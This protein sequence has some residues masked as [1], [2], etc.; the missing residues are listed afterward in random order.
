MNIALSGSHGFIGGGL[1]K[2]LEFLGNTVFP[3]SRELRLSPANLLMFMNQ[4]MIDRVIDCAAYGNHSFQTNEDEVVKANVRGTYNMFQLIKRYNVPFFNFSTTSHNLEA[5]TFYGSIK[6]AG[7]YMLRAFV[8]TYK[9]PMVNIR[10][11]SVY[12][13]REWEFRFIPTITE[14]IRKGEE[15]TVSDVSHDW[16][17]IEDFLDG[18]MEVFDH[19]EKYYGKAVGIGTG[20]RVPNMT[21]AETLMA[22]AGIDVPIKTGT[23]R[24]YEIA[25]HEVM[26]NGEK[27]ND[28]I[29]LFQFAKTSLT[30]GLLNVYTHPQFLRLAS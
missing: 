20:T 19:H 1:K 8:N 12:G 26:K 27:R 5:S 14:K 30:Q 9:L 25:N 18:F 2:R 4:N 17:Y 10:P 29:Q 7:E 21:V 13:E 24:S 11:Y 22:I 28:E 16:I 3:I 15:I 23:L 6:S